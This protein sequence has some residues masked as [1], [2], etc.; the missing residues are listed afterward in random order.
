MALDIGLTTE[1]GAKFSMSF[2]DDENG[3]YYW[4]LYPL[5]VR[6]KQSTGQWIDLYESAEF[7]GEDL[8]AL[9]DT[10][11]EARGMVLAQPERW[12][13]HVGTE[14][15]SVARDLFKEVERSRFLALIDGLIDLVKEAQATGHSIV[16]AGD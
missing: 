5:F 7:R 3:G 14:C 1:D 13:V 8:A 11:L 2:D 15:G 9:N 4:F 6:L 12:A 10:L 16:F